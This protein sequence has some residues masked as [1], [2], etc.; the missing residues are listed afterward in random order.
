MQIK[1]QLQNLDDIALLKT[2]SKLASKEN[3]VTLDLLY[4]LGEVE[5]RKLY[6]PAGFSSMF[7]Y[8]TKELCYS[9][10]AAYRRI[11]C[12]KA[13]RQFPDLAEQ[14]KSR[15]L[16]L[17]TLALAAKILN[18]ENYQEVISCVCGKSKREVEE[19]LCRYAPKI[20]APKE[21][22]R[23]FVVAA[24]ST[25]AKLL[26]GAGAKSGSLVRA[27]PAI[28][29][30]E[31]SGQ[32]T[33]SSSS[34][35]TFSG[36]SKSNPLASLEPKANICV[37]GAESFRRPPQVEERYELKFSIPAGTRKKLDEARLLLSGKY[38]RGVKLEDVFEEALE[39]LLE[40]RSPKRR[41]ERRAKRESAKVG[42]EKSVVGAAADLEDAHRRDD[43]VDVVSKDSSKALAGDR[44]S[45][46]LVKPS[47]APSRHLPQHLRDLVHVR[48]E[49]CCA[50]VGSDGR[51]CQEDRDLEIHHVKPYGRGGAHELS[52]LKCFCRAHNLHQAERDYGR[53]YI[54]VKTNAARIFGEGVCG[55]V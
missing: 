17:T 3:E 4:H 41:L 50:F 8:V 28:I 34:P 18:A 45:A 12:A 36:E 40:R 21:V 51:R 54:G 2:L 20:T 10:P 53:D 32:M 42:V 46:Q 38:P 37:P 24:A 13:L 30:A 14:L 15:Q 9:E 22:V 35:F 43:G 19:Y 25:G 23:P 27:E 29:P 55:T 1:D 31:A 48:D 47:Q 52:N 7:S 5:A 33:H 11:V 26:E 6:L 16:S 44:I 49:G 39:L